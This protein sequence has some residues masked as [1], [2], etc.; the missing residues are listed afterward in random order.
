MRNPMSHKLTGLSVIGVSR[1][2]EDNS[3]AR[4]LPAL[5]V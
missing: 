5:G 3:P 2:D 1:Y 4:A